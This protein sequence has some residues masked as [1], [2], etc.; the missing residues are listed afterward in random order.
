MMRETQFLA[1]IMEQYSNV[2]FTTQIFSARSQA[3]QRQVPERT[4]CKHPAP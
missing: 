3:Q 4:Y 2:T 1:V